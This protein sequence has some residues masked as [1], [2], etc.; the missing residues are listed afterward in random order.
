M[1]TNKGVTDISQPSLQGDGVAVTAPL[2]AT[3]GP[4][5]A[6]GKNDNQ[7][8]RGANPILKSGPLFISSKGIGWTSWKKRW[9]ILTKTSLVFFRSDPSVVAQK[10]SEANLTLGGIDLNNSGSVVVKVDKKLLTVLFPDGRDGRAF[11]LKAETSEDLFE[12]RN[13]LEIA[14]A[15]APSTHNVLGQNVMGQ[16]GVIRNDQPEVADTKVEKSAANDKPP[17]ASLVLGRPIL[18]ALEDVDGSP[19]FLEK[20]LKFIEEYGKTE[21]IPGEDAH[22]VG[23]CIKYFLRELPSS[24]V[25]ASCCHALLDACRSGNRVASMR[26][27]IME[28]FPEPN[29]RLLQ[30]ILVMMQQVA[31]HKERNRMSISAVSA[32]MAPL[33][34]RP[35]LSGDCEIEND[36]D[37]GGDGS[38][39]LLQAAAAANH[40]QAIVIT[41]MEEYESI[42][43]VRFLLFTLFLS[44]SVIAFFYYSIKWMTL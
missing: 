11:T 1:T 10:G 41:L 30:R 34:L 4:A 33:L 2:S 14:L 43:S 23:D 15:Q 9:F 16:N 36:F 25:P 5:A 35:L 40:A 32:C 13:A 8:Y 22:V 17:P 24:P 37:V 38:M 12:W 20:A 3:G 7:A 6:G 31:A 42:F 39:Q 28:T 29:R 21:F 27:A 19:S 26:T 44:S 18:L